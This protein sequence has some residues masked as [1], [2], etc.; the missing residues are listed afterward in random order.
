MLDGDFKSH[1]EALRKSNPGKK[2]GFICQAGVRSA[3]MSQLL[4][5]AGLTG[6]VDVTGG[7][8]QW[9]DVGLPVSL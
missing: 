8:R 5:N 1:I 3:Q 2:I 6:I 9:I 4:E 7:T